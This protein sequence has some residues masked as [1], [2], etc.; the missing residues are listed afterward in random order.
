LKKNAQ[1]DFLVETC[2]FL[3]ALTDDDDPSSNLIDSGSKLK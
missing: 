3:D 2:E 1:Y